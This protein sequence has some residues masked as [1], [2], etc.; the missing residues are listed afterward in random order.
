M[1]IKSFVLAT[2]MTAALGFSASAQ[3]TLFQVTWSGAQYENGASAVGI[4]DIDTNV[5]PDTLG[6][7]NFHG[8]PDAA[9]QIV[10]VTVSGSA[11]GNGTFT[12]AD[13]ASYYF[14]AYGPL[15][16]SQELVG[17]TMANG[18]VFGSFNTCY[19]GPSGDFN[20]FTSNGLS[21]QG[22]FYF[23]LTTA[24]GDNI[25]VVSIKPLDAVPEPASWAML[26][27]GFGLVGAA[28]RRRKLVAA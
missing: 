8:L 23:Q 3:A 15:D 12:G 13:F 4:F 21:P 19:G 16:F 2:A 1:S 24:G 26:I 14:A 9:F 20:L 27:A 28:Q 11:G 10:S 6:A 7:Q 25:A 18:C 5:V 22:T 17:Q